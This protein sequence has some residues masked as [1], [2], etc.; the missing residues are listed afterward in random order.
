MTGGQDR[1]SGTRRT[2]SQLG[3]PCTIFQILVEKIFMAKEGRQAPHV[4]VVQRPFHSQIQYWLDE[5]E[6]APRPEV[7]VV[8][9]TRQFDRGNL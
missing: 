6:P 2:G 8:F 1:M 9:R 5:R 4:N 7:H 3:V